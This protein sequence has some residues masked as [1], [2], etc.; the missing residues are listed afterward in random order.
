MLSL[1]YFDAITNK[2]YIPSRVFAEN[3]TLIGTVSGIEYYEHPRYGDEYPLIAYDREL[4]LMGLSNFWEL[5][6]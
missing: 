1:T 3:P 4:N 5:P 6:E 2:K